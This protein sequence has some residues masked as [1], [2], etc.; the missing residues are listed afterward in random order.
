MQRIEAPIAE[1]RVGTMRVLT[2]KAACT[3]LVLKPS[4]VNGCV[5][6]RSTLAIQPAL[7]SG[8]QIGEW[9]AQEHQQLLLGLTGVGKDWKRIQQLMVPSRSEAEVRCHLHP[10]NA[11]A[12]VVHAPHSRSFSF[13]T[14]PPLCRTLDS[15]PEATASARSSTATIHTAQAVFGKHTHGTAAPLPQF[16]PGGGPAASWTW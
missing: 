12:R 6:V 3:R 7:W 2:P 10:S 4:T 13:A 11:R 1:G 8:R 16:G 9:T 15:R 14:D 5:Q